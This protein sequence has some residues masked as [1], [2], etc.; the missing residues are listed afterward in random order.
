M[1]GLTIEAV[2]LW[3]LDQQNSL[4]TLQRWVRE[5]VENTWGRFAEIDFAPQGLDAMTH[6]WPACGAIPPAQTLQLDFSASSDVAERGRRS[7][8]ST[9]IQIQIPKLDRTTLTMSVINLFGQAL[10]LL[11]TAGSEDPQP[12]DIALAQQLYGRKHSGALVSWGG[13]CLQPLNAPTLVVN[14]NS[15]VVQSCVSAAHQR[16]RP[17][18]TAPAGD[19]GFQVAYAESGG[20]YCAAAQS[21]NSLSTWICGLGFQVVPPAG[22]SL[23]GWGDLCVATSAAELGAHLSLQPCAA[24]PLQRWDLFTNFDGQIRLSGTTWCAAADDRSGPPGVGTSLRL[25]QCSAQDPNQSFDLSIHDHV[26]FDRNLCVQ[27][28]PTQ[29]GANAP[30]RLGAP[31]S[32]HA[33]EQMFNVTGAVGT[34][35]LGCVTLPD[36]TSFPGATVAVRTCSALSSEA[37]NLPGWQEW[38][39]HW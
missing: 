15:Y 33:L 11:D 24:S 36:H 21:D 32:P 10:G 6:E 25:V 38:D 39:Y 3:T 1:A 35:N 26:R 16:W 19:L 2:S 30:L 7:D 20:Y 34:S 28:D 22:A 5:A 17:V 37:R 18:I 12:T 27:V 31:C 23:R 29:L 4:L 14:G 13:R 9:R 8:R